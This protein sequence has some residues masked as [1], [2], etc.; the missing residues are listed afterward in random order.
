MVYLFK[1]ISWS[2]SAKFMFIP[3]MTDQQH[4]ADLEFSVTVKLFREIIHV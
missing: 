4:F 2:K 1:E 3:L